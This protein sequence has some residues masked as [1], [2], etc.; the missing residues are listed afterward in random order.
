[1][2]AGS[3]LDLIVI[4]EL[5]DLS[6]GS[7]WMT[8]FTQRLI[9]ALSVETGEGGLYEVDMRLR[10]SGRAGPVAVRLPAF[11]RYHLEEAWTWERMALTRMRV[12]TGDAGLTAKLENTLA[13]IHRAAIPRAI[14]TADI[15][16][17]RQRLIREKPGGNWLDMKLPVGGLIDIE[18]IAQAGLLRLANAGSVMPSTRDAIR[19]GVRSGFI[20][21]ADGG[22]LC[23]VHELFS[24]LQQV[25]RLAIIGNIDEEDYPKGLKDRMARAI[26]VDD[27][28]ALKAKV[29]DTK[30]RIASLRDQY[31]GPLS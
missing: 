4:Y 22:L 28:G 10:P 2:T 7:Q 3:D 30:A 8:R 25:Q 11:E 6:A 12:I 18:F 1:M 24:T 15:L 5:E 20:A 17:M 19:A 9:T 26:E 23:E 16:D 27:F 13:S 14:L 29:L 21:D 31:I